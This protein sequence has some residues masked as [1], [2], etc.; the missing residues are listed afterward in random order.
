M[1]ILVVGMSPRCIDRGLHM[2]GLESSSL[3]IVT[4]RVLSMWAQPISVLKGKDLGW[5]RAL[6]VF[7]HCWLEK[8]WQHG[9]KHYSFFVEYMYITCTST[10][11][12]PR[13]SYAINLYL[14]KWD[15]C[16]FIDTLYQCQ[17]WHM[18]FHL[19]HLPMRS[20]LECRSR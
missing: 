13:E 8:L 20:Y 18:M 2:P 14:T 19:S 11:T 5:M 1:L 12:K 9:T 17:L 16:H 7:W 6:G 15:I 4:I 3:L 10:V